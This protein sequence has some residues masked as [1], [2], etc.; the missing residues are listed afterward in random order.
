[1]SPQIDDLVLFTS[2]VLSTTMTMTMQD[3]ALSV[4]T[5]IRKSQAVT[6][7]VLQRNGVPNE[8]IGTTQHNSNAPDADADAAAAVV[9]VARPDIRL[10]QVDLVS[11][12]FVYS[13][14]IR[15]TAGDFKYFYK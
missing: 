9:V 5:L 15:V 13:T 3:T 4:G 2:A 14:T 1:M 8:S 11:R 12:I 6:T 10:L 7:V